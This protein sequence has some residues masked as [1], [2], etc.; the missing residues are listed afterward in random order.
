MLFLEKLPT[1]INARGQIFLPQA[2]VLSQHG[3]ATVSRFIAHVRLLFA[4][5]LVAQRC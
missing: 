3:T 4:I 5:R 2:D 1:E